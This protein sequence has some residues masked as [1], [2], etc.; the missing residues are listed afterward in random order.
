M[1]SEIGR[2][3]MDLAKS[4]DI[5]LG[6]LDIIISAMSDTNERAVWSNRLGS[7]IRSINEEII[8]PLEKEFPELI[9]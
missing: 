6:E 1:K 8:I 2:S 9:D 3:M 7:V 5:N 4:L